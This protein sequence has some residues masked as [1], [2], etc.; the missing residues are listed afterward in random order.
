MNAITQKIFL[1]FSNVYVPEDS[2]EMANE[3]FRSAI[4]KVENAFLGTNVDIVI[5]KP[6][7]GEYSTLD[8]TNIAFEGA[9]YLGIAEFDQ[10][11]NPSDNGAIRLDNIMDYASNNF[12]L[13]EQA[14]NLLAN[15]ITHEIGHLMGLDHSN[16]PFDIMHDG[17]TQNMLDDPPT[18]G[19][20]QIQAINTNAVIANVDNNIEITPEITD[21]IGDIDYNSMDSS[22]IDIDDPDFDYDSLL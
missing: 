17:V 19:M 14:S 9:D 7:A 3:L 22:E 11:F 13:E 2:L 5:E 18:F 12:L 20:E 8:M 15:T 21:E 1:D 16:D 10:S 6:H 4:E